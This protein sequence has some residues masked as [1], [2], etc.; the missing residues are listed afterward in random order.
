MLEQMKE[1]I[2]TTIYVKLVEIERLYRELYECRDRYEL[3]IPEIPSRLSYLAVPVNSP[4]TK[5]DSGRYMVCIFKHH[6]HMLVIGTDRSPSPDKSPNNTHLALSAPYR[7][8]SFK[9]KHE[10][11]RYTAKLLAPHP[12]SAAI[13]IRRLDDIAQWLRNRIAGLE[14]HAQHVQEQIRSGKSYAYLQER[15]REAAVIS[16]LEQ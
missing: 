10:D 12:R 3:Q 1:Q 4:K 11:V 14:R 15:Y 9:I 8:P 5:D 13:L 6:D 2:Q 7:V 16:Q